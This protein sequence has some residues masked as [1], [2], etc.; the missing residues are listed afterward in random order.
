[1]QFRQQEHADKVLKEYRYPVI[2]GEQCRA[3]PFNYKFRAT[4]T[5]KKPK[6]A[7]CTVFVKNCPQDWT[8]EDLYEHFKQYGDVLSA[9]MSIDG[10]Y[11]SRGYGF[12]TFDNA[13]AGQKA[14]EEANDMPHS[15]LYSAD[16]ERNS[17]E[18]CKLVVSEF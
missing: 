3:L 11:K 16:P 9:K 2:K 10:N 18:E 5:E 6:D 12:V 4:T 8:H 15:K 17:E 14:L 1:M 7:P 13:K